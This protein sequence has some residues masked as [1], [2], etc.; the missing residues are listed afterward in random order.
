MNAAGEGIVILIIGFAAIWGA[1]LV[2]PP[3][4]GETWAGLLPMGTA[5]CLTLSGAMMSRSGLRNRLKKTSDSMTTGPGRPWLRVLALIILAILYHQAIFNFGYELSTAAVGP[6]VLWTF[7]VRN[8]WGLALS[9]ILYPVIFHLLFFKL[10]GVFPPF[11]NIF[12]LLDYLR[13]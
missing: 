3:P 1:S 8:K 6:I 10:L 7:G 9:V 12:D 2:P 11:G 5:I 4:V 13:G